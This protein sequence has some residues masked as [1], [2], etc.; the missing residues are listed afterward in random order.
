MNKLSLKAKVLISL[1]L[2]GLL[3]GATIASMFAFA[4]HSD[5]VN[6]AYSNLKP[7]EL[8]N[9]FSAIR[10]EEGNLKPEI[11]ILDP[12]KK[13]IVAFLDETYTKFMFANDESKQYDFDE[14]FNKY[15]EIYQESFILEVKYGSFS[16]YNEYVTAVKPLQFIDFTKWFFNNVA[17]GPDLLTLESFRI[18]P[19]VEQNGNAITLGSHSTV[20]KES[21]EI[22]F[23]P[24]A[25]FGSMPIYSGAS[26]S[27]NASDA[28]TYSLFSDRTSKANI[29]AFFE[30]IEVASAVK[31]A[32][33][34]NNASVFLSLVMPER[35]VGKKFLVLKN[36]P[37]KDD[38]FHEV[39]REKQRGKGSI[40]LSANATESEFSKYLDDNNLDSS[41]YSFNNFELATVTAVDSSSNDGNPY[42]E[43]TFNFDHDA[44]SHRYRMF[45]GEVDP[46][47]YATYQ[48]YKKS[49]DNQIVSFLDFYDIKAYEKN[50][51]GTDSNSLWAYKTN[52][53]Y[54]FFRSQVEAINS[55]DELKNYNDLPV[56][57]KTKLREYVVESLNV[58]ENILEIKLDGMQINF[59]ANKMDNKD[60]EIF[61]E[62]KFA[63]GY[64]GAITPIALQ[65]GPEDVKAKDADGNQL[66]GLDS[67]NYQVFV[68]TYDG[69]VDK[70]LNKYPH[71]R[72]KRTGPHIVKKLNSKFVYEY[73]IEDGDY[74]GL[75]DTD[76]IGLPLL[77]A[78]SL[79]GFKGLSTDFLK[80]V[81]AH[82]YGHHYTLDQSQALNENQRAVIVGGL[83]TRGGLNESSYY[84]I[85]ALK[86]YLYARTNL[87]ITRVN[88]LGNESET[89]SFVNFIFKKK[90]G[91]TEKETKEDIW[92]S[93]S[94][95]RDNVYEIIDNKKRRFL[96]DFDGLV[97][98]AELRNVH[99][100]DLFIANSFDEESGT[101]N[102]FISG[103]AKVFTKTGENNYKFTE[104]QAKEILKIVRDGMGTEWN[105]EALV[106]DNNNSNRFEINPVTFSGQGEERQVTSINMFNKDGS[107]VISVPLN[108]P[109]TANDLAYI[110]SQIQ[111]IRSS[112]NNVISRFVSESGWNDISTSFGGEVKVGATGILNASNGETIKN[113]L[114]FRNDDVEIDPSS[115][116]VL[117]DN[118]Q[119][120][121]F[122]YTAIASTGTLLNQTASILSSGYA[123]FNSQENPHTYGNYALSQ[124]N[125]TFVFVSGEQG[126][127]TKVA[128]Y[129]VPWIQNNGTLARLTRPNDR[130]LENIRGLGFDL[131]AAFQTSFHTEF[132]RSIAG[133]V[134]SASQNQA[135][136]IIFLNDENLK[137]DQ[138]RFVSSE[139]QNEYLRE[140]VKK[141]ALNNVNNRL[142][143]NDS[144]YSA[145]ADGVGLEIR[146]GN[147][148]NIMPVF[149]NMQNLFEFASLDY[150]KAKLVS[151][152]VKDNGTQ[153][154]TFNWDIDYVKTKF[155]LDKLKAELLKNKDA[156]IQEI[157]NDEQKLANEAILRF[158][159]SNHMLFVKDFNPAKELKANLAIF[160][161][162][163]G[164][165]F[166]DHGFRNS[167][168]F[169]FSKITDAQE[170]RTKFDAEKLQ[171]EFA[172]Y[173]T[174]LFKDDAPDK[175][176]DIVDSLNTQD[177]YRLTGNLMWFDNH[178]DTSDGQFDILIPSFSDGQP[179]SDV[180][181]YNLTRVEP[182]L[183]DK[184]TDYIYNIAETLT[185]DYVQTTYVPNWKDFE[186]L[187]NFISGVTEAQTG[188]DYIVDATGLKFWN[189]RINNQNNINRSVYQAIRAAKYDKYLPLVKD[190]FFEFIQDKKVLD[191]QLRTLRQ[192]VTSGEIKSKNADGTTSTRKLTSE[193]L[194]KY[195]TRYNSFLELSVQQTSD[196]N[197]K[198]GKIRSRVYGD[199]LNTQRRT[200]ASSE[201]R[202]SS[203]FANLITRNNGYFKDR[204]Q[205][206]KIGM[207]LYDEN[208]DQIIDDSIRL[209]DFNG[210]A[211]TSRPKAFFVSQ[212][213]NYGVGSRSIS[214]IFRNKNKDAVAM[215]GYI[216]NEEAKDVKWIKFTD[217]KT[218]EEKYLPVNIAKT[219]N[220]FYLEKQGDLSSKKT[221]ED[222]GYTSWVSDFA[223]MGKY[224][225][226]LLKPRHSY[227]VEFV[228]AEKQFV[229]DVKLGN[230]DYI[231]ENGKTNSQASI[232]VVKGDEN[233][234]EEKGKSVILVDFQFNITG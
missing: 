98:A 10:D 47:W 35:L 174:R 130:I 167:F 123:S 179:S 76:R 94:S 16:F 24:D 225:D 228:N 189:D 135:N 62:V 129:T 54:K 43:V 22:K 150:S 219:N 17:W 42:L 158:R 83:S 117:D 63:L 3:S 60:I 178:G 143:G 230:L 142:N 185:R 56:S 103:I 110:D 107:P 115:N 182:L 25:F 75:N 72:V 216:S 49:L 99:L 176:N 149:T 52:E 144:L 195:Q 138:T 217:L 5:E 18:V 9:D 157:A 61:N 131:N 33:A 186:G 224:R 145:Y 109:L 78:A 180:L 104:V 215:Y 71:L 222:L 165:H 194:A 199:F 206:E 19:G 139:S 69:L 126:S 77:M 127:R 218:K 133:I 84:S 102:P 50:S 193:E 183:N 136:D 201:M 80:Y 204:F 169:D 114:L 93:T 137:I 148:T 67:R 232:K 11:S 86:N 184:F 31:N 188:L 32:I 55:I 91:S 82:E 172:K 214:G 53:G 146:T 170:Q 64:T 88:S 6:G 4:K 79:P 155:N 175:I 108:T 90:D 28:L 23:F 213:L 210:E 128:S 231:S 101:L 112:F 208:A 20:H 85:D 36:D 8:R 41:K 51:N 26:G 181:N 160:S 200:M 1:G 92:G 177:L 162:E 38:D 196:R 164:I 203:Y 70:I 118:N 161:K 132:W 65:A 153:S 95:K 227:L 12:S 97:K 156:R 46:L 15:F 152:E 229:A 116:N 209:K 27:G 122:E 168:V 81:G 96:Q 166:N 37:I 13:N 191:V 226:A 154:A 68:E 163:Y 197:E 198:T 223:V 89:G 171:E 87:D 124:T 113:N 234:K 119:R 59:D 151:V 57:E 140:N 220:V 192:I 111:I 100:G 134:G 121:A 44:S 7:E 30:S 106:F 48:S 74:Y 207:E 21:S 141:I 2:I 147:S 211:I 14:F 233:K 66:K 205:K 212:L 58:K 73:S 159:N 29:D 120:K 125:N 39:K 173:V 45:E 202:N 187:P 105:A 40:V 221:V 190:I 34:R